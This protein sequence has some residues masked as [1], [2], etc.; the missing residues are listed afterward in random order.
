[1]ADNVVRRPTEVLLVPGTRRAL[2]GFFVCGL[3][4]SFTGA[5][6]LAWGHHISSHY[7]TIGLYFLSLTAGI[8]V[9][10]RLA[11]ALLPSKGVGFVLMLGCTVACG[12]ILFLAGVGPPVPAAWRMAGLAG[13]GVAAGLLQAAIF[14]AI[15][16]MYERDRAAT[17]NLAG[18]LLGGGCLAMALLVSGTFYVYTAP[19]ILILVATIPG[20]F[21]IMYARTSYPARPL[22]QH[23]SIVEGLKQLRSPIA[24][25]LALLLFFQFGNEWSMA[26]WLPLFL[27]QRL[28]ISPEQSLQLLALYWVA[29]I[30]GR[31][32][33][34]SILPHVSHAKL[35]FLSAIAAVFGS[36]VLAVTNNRF[37]AIAGVLLIGGAW[38]PI[39]PLVVEKIGSRFPSYR[40]GFF[41]GIFSIAFTGALL[42]PCSLGF[43]V[44]LWGIRAVMA[45]PVAGTILVSVLVLAIWLEARISG[46][47]GRRSVASP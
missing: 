26:G 4:L 40:P 32:L 7:L 35:L 47:Q 16:P 46:A 11:Q 6:L 18:M 42:A 13:I 17:V 20:L 8:L 2:A 28:G 41:N 30:A 45:L 39:Y 23:V 25:L 38:A 5:I 33:A 9:S 19:S 36:L 43:F 3:L 37:G 29:L 24:V 22:P 15:S 44:E 34:Q 10:L 27:V 1:M 12:A 21:A 14:Q 31:I